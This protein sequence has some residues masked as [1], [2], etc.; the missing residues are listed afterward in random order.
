MLATTDKNPKSPRLPATRFTFK[1]KNE[2]T[3]ERESFCVFID[4]LNPPR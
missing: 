3:K 1:D 4:F 2:D